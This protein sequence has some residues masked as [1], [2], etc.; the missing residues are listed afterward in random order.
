MVIFHSYVS[1][2]EGTY[3]RLQIQPPGG[4]SILEKPRR[5]ASRLG[6]A[7]RSR[8]GLLEKTETSL[9][10]PE[11]QWIRMDHT[12]I[13]MYRPN[14]Y[15]GL[16]RFPEMILSSTKS[17][18][19]LVMT[20]MSNG[21]PMVWGSII[22]ENLHIGIFRLNPSG[23]RSIWRYLECTLLP[24]HENVGPFVDSTDAL[25]QTNP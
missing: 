21:K 25:E 23:F 1:L 12:S 19:L 13:G 20:V 17:S 5:Q 16:W 22:F 11:I 8:C 4:L 3:H 6:D 14:R 7:I 9:G 24:L 15:G 2:P 10:R 18:S